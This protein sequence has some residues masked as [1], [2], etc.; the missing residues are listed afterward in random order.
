LPG[1]ADRSETAGHGGA[2]ASVGDRVWEH[3]VDLY[4]SRAVEVVALANATAAL[5][6]PLSPAYPDIGAEVVYGV[7]R[8]YCVRLDDFMRRRTLLAASADRGAQ[9]VAT[10]AALMARELS[11]SPAHQAAE[12]ATAL[13]PPG[14]DLDFSG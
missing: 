10:A 2:A 12:A 8:E 14:S 7:R 11:W 5:G 1:A 13:H 6:A 3:L 9:A 4:G